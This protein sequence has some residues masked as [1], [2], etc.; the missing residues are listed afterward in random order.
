MART[1]N[2][3]YQIARERMVCVFYQN[4]PVLPQ[5]GPFSC[6][7]AL[8]SRKRAL[9]DIARTGSSICQITRERMVCVLYQKSSK[10]NQKSPK[11]CSIKRDP[12]NLMGHMNVTNSTPHT[13]VCQIARERMVCEFYQKCFIMPRTT[14]S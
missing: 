12:T 7:R 8:S 1:G 10:F 4:S 3:I 5:K 9:Y 6:K 13:A 11:L 2:S 14:L